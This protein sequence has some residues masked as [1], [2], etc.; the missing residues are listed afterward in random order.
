MIAM[1][2][3]GKELRIRPEITGSA[4]AYCS[5]Q[6]ETTLGQISMEE[7]LENRETEIRKLK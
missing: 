4:I 7:Y 6:Q 1:S 3:L 5:F 2:D